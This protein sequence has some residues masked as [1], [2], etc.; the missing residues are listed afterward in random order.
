MFEDFKWRRGSDELSVIDRFAELASKAVRHDI[1]ACV[2]CRNQ[3]H[4]ARRVSLKKEG[5]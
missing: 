1:A 5:F 2:L 4:R 3:K